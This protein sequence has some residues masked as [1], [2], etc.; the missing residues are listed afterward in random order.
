MLFVFFGCFEEFVEG[1]EEEEEDYISLTN[2]ER[3]KT[4]SQGQF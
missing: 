4:N 3:R 1:E 2:K